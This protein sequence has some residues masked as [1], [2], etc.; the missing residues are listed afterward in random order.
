MSAADDESRLLRVWEILPKVKNGM[1][2]IERI[3]HRFCGSVAPQTLL[4][5]LLLW[6]QKPCLQKIN[7]SIIKTDVF[8]LCEQ[9]FHC[10]K[11][12]FASNVSGE[13]KRPSLSA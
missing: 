13:P 7:H 2:S 12:D 5:K 8:N 1:K 10:R 6:Q 11:N 3:L 4:A 9:G